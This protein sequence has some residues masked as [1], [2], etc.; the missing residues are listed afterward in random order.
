MC[1][2]PFDAHVLPLAS[3]ESHL[4][5]VKQSCICICCPLCCRSKKGA[6][7]HLT[8]GSAR[9]AVIHNLVSESCLMQLCL[10]A[11]RMLLTGEDKMAIASRLTIEFAFTSSLLQVVLSVSVADRQRAG[12]G[13]NRQETTLLLCCRMD[14]PP[15]LTAAGGSDLGH[16]SACAD[17]EKSLPY[18]T[19]DEIRAVLGQILQGS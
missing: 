14:M 1:S 19:K 4:C 5:Y 17:L 11:S 16:S 15:T 10:N 12:R 6:L 18:Q 13:V 3:F 9:L 2:H 8:R 7:Q